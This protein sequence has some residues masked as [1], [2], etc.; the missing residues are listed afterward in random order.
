LPSFGEP[1]VPPTC[2]LSRTL[3]NSSEF[4]NSIDPSLMEALP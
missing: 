4:R 1:H 3:S 2:G